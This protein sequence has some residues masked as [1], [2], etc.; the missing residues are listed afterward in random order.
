MKR[1]ITL[2][3]E[4]I[5]IAFFLIMPQL[6]FP[7]CATAQSSPTI[8]KSAEATSGNGSLSSGFV[9]LKPEQWDKIK[10]LTGADKQRL[11]RV[12]ECR[13]VNCKKICVPGCD[14]PDP[15][16]TITG[17]SSCYSWYYECDLVCKEK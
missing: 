10:A 1:P 17:C 4:L 8:K 6:F 14:P 5:I 2:P 12:L 15:H 16:G 9:R 11:A 13:L 7:S 3:M